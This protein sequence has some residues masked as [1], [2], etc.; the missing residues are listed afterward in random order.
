MRLPVPS[1]SR[2]IARSRDLERGDRILLGDAPT[3]NRQ[4]PTSFLEMLWLWI[5]V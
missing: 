4:G 2:N 5:F 3:H 1:C